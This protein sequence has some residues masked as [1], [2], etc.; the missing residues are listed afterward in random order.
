[1]NRT[2]PH[3]IC[4]IAVDGTEAHENDNRFVDCR[5]MSLEDSI[6]DSVIIANWNG[7]LVSLDTVQATIQRGPDQEI[8][9]SD[10]S[11]E[12]NLITPGMDVVYLEFELVEGDN[13]FVVNIES[14]HEIDTYYLSVVRDTT[15]PELT[16]WEVSNRTSPLESK[17]MVS[18]TCERGANVLIWSDVDSHQFVCPIS[19]EYTI[20]V[21]VLESPGEHAIS[22]L[23]TDSAN[24]EI[25]LEISVL[26]QEWAD[27]AIEDARS[28][29][30]MMWWFSLAFILLLSAVVA[31]A[32]ALA[33]RRSK[34]R[35]IA[36]HG[37]DL[38]EIMA[39]IEAAADNQLAEME[40]E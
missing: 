31:P 20:E 26:K 9:W 10:Y 3:Q 40:E 35:R 38:D 8:W 12:M 13:Q 15:S 4:I 22:A 29:G 33:R 39:E 2:G 30:P 23:S 21:M 28:G 25:R 18:G 11:S 5:E 27:W 36:S 34:S 16:I 14:L 19:E 17:R 1:M 37:P 32:T 7:G 6:Y 24:N